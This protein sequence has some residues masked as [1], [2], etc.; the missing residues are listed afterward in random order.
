MGR[1]ALGLQAT[2][3]LPGSL[4]VCLGFRVQD[5]GLDAQSGF[6]LMLDRA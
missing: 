4:L 2:V 1:D 6:F 5:V 3:S